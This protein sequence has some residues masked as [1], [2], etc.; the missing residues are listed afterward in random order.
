MKESLRKY[1]DLLVGGF[2]MAFGTTVSIALL[3]NDFL[4]IN[5]LTDFLGVTLAFT[6]TYAELGY[7]IKFL[8]P[9]TKGAQN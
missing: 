8:L 1:I 5:S 6:L 3:F 4:P 9:M 7:I 2:I